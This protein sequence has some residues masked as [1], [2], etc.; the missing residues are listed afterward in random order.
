MN[1]TDKELKAMFG[2]TPD[3]FTAAMERAIAG[4]KHAHDAP[5]PRRLNRLWSIVLVVVLALALTTGAYA[6]AVRLGFIDLMKN[7]AFSYIPQ[8]ALDVLQATEVR[9]WEVGPLTVTFNEAIADG[10]L[11][12]VACQAQVTDGSDALL[13]GW[14]MDG[15]TPDVLKQKLGLEDEWLVDAAQHY[16]GPVYAVETWLEMDESLLDGEQMMVDPY[17]G[18]DGSILSAYMVD[19]DPELIGD[20]VEAAMRVRVSRMEI[21]DVQKNAE[22][23]RSNREIVERWEEVFPLELPVT[24]VIETKTYKP[25]GDGDLGGVTV[26]HVYVERTPVGL[27]TYTTLRLADETSNED[28][29]FSIRFLTAEDERFPYSGLYQSGYID[30]TNAPEIKV[31]EFI[32]ADDMPEAMHIYNRMNDMTIEIR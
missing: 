5:A 22:V 12:F 23:I 10:Q 2:Q 26:E 31:M 20:T 11:V 14:D 25:V 15:F 32:S 16:G 7:G 8:S 18:S 6:A 21:S 29:R 28:R 1:P 17:W 4:E 13:C 24:G 9:S 3:S 27:Y 30:D 19:T